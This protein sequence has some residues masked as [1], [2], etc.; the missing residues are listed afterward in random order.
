MKQFTRKDVGTEV[1]YITWARTDRNTEPKVQKGIIT[2][3]G[4]VNI[5]IDGRDY[6]AIE[7]RDYCLVVSKGNITDH[8]VKIFRNEEDI[9][10][11]Q[12]A[13]Q[14]RIR[15]KKMDFSK[16][17]ISQVERIIQLLEG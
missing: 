8:Y 11:Q 15:L 14:M 2:K 4:K 7:T 1:F 5:G 13:E 16:L 10:N 17:P 6:K 3:V 9:S 12:R